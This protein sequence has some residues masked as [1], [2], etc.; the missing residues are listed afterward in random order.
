MPRIPRKPISATRPPLAKQDEYWAHCGD[1]R[2][3]WSHPSN[4]TR[5]RVASATMEVHTC[6]VLGGSAMTA[7][8]GSV[9]VARISTRSATTGRNR[10]RAI[11]AR[12][13]YSY[14]LESPNAITHAFFMINYFV[15]CARQATAA[16][17]ASAS[18]S[19]YTPTP[20]T[21]PGRP[22]VHHQHNARLAFG[23]TN[24]PIIIVFVLIY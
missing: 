17:L 5:T 12:Y 10:S 16:S 23:C 3:G 22:P 20:A 7:Q 19:S 4:T 1:W 9:A 15:L 24:I 6:T 14:F 13:N 8:R 2:A 21:H 11:S 18:S